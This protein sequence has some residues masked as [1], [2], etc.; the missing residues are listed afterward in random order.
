MDGTLIDICT[1]RSRN[2]EYYLTS[3]SELSIKVMM[4]TATFNMEYNCSNLVHTSSATLLQVDP[5]QL[6]LARQVAAIILHKVFSINDALG[7]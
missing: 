4:Y 1:T 7:S 6:Y 5:L 2:V 3:V